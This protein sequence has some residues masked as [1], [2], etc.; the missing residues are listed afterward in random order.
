MQTKISYYFYLIIEL[1]RGFQHFETKNQIFK[2]SIDRVHEYVY[3]KNL[4][5]TDNLYSKS[6][7]CSTPYTFSKREGK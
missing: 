3:L 5:T 7:N 2:K 6:C 1:T 4:F